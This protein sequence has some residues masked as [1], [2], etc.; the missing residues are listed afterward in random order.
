MAV[1]TISPYT[2]SIRRGC[3]EAIIRASGLVGEGDGDCLAESVLDTLV[4]LNSQEL[5]LSDPHSAKRCGEARHEAPRPLGDFGKKTWP[6]D[7]H[8]IVK[9]D[10]AGQALVNIMDELVW[11]LVD[12]V[13]VQIQ[14]NKA[15]Q[16]AVPL[17]EPLPGFMPLDYATPG[18]AS[19]S[20]LLTGFVLCVWAMYEA[21]RV[22]ESPALALMSVHHKASVHES[23]DGEGT[24]WWTR[25]CNTD[26]EAVILL[27]VK[28]AELLV[29]D[30]AF[31]IRPH[32]PQNPPLYCYIGGGVDRQPDCIT[33]LVV[34]TKDPALTAAV[35]T[36][37]RVLGM[38]F[39]K[40]VP[41]DL[42][43]GRIDA[44]DFPTALEDL[45]DRLD[46]MWEPWNEFEPHH[47][48]TNLL[49]SLQGSPAGW[50]AASTPTADVVAARVADAV[51]DGADEGADWGD[52]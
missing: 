16:I 32:K 51:A 13:T 44:G 12:H 46:A 37:C 52:D 50:M 48:K 30:A 22:P 27:N 25:A 7:L 43:P 5:V 40:A 10:W 2:K 19:G 24:T 18:V 3:A 49:G 34:R 47:A 31:Y 36:V 14:G 39:N 45:H 1:D 21:H 41:W 6:R 23:G 33:S 8:T 42:K 38:T 29:Q 9:D 4:T 26:R 28:D 15:S 11:R 17:L 20:Q 35:V